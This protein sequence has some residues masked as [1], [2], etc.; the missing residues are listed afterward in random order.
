MHVNITIAFV[1]RALG[2]FEARLVRI[3]AR[4]VVEGFNSDKEGLKK[5]QKPEK[6]KAIIIII[7]I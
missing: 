3:E 7:S 2:L 6:T 1:L 5:T 4:D